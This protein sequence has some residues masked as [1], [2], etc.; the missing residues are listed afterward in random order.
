LEWLL[1]LFI[2]L[3]YGLWTFTRSRSSFKQ[4]EVFF[5]AGVYRH[6]GD[7]GQAIALH[8]K[9]LAQL[10][11]TPQQRAVV[12]L[13][14]AE[15]YMRAGLLGSGETCLLSLLYELKE[16]SA[17]YD[18][19][20][21]LLLS[22]YE[23]E[24]EWDKAID[25]ALQ[26]ATPFQDPIFSIVVAHYLCEKAEEARLKNQEVLFYQHLNN[27]LDMDKSSVRTRLLYGDYLSQKKMYIEAMRHYQEI[28][29]CDPRFVTIMA[30][31]MAYCYAHSQSSQHAQ[32]SIVFYIQDLLERYPVPSL[33]FLYQQYHTA[34]RALLLRIL[35]AQDRASSLSYLITDS[36]RRL[37]DSAEIDPALHPFLQK[38]FQQDLGYQCDRCGFSSIRLDWQCPGCKKWAGIKPKEG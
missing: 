8:E 27:A 29:R 16:D 31:R 37:P 24:K 2:S 10:T 1:L 26:R 38:I 36:L 35:E 18:K 15:D 17:E 4:Q 11:L 28:E 23:Q 19:A 34:D 21:W 25:L 5:L 14:L 9:L 30:G 12:R 32:Q 22:I 33:F 7:V 6:Q 20:C 3:F 13:A